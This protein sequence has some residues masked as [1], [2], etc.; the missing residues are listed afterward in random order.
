MSYTN[1]NL[2]T[3][4]SNALHNAIV[5]VG[6]KDRPPMLA[7]EGSSITTTEGYMENYKNVSQDIR[8]QVDA[9]AEVVQIILTWIDNDIYS[10]VNA[11]LRV[12]STTIVSKPQLKSNRLED[13]VMHNNSK[14]KKQ[15]VDDHRGNFNFSNNETS[16]TVCNDS[17]NAKTLKLVQIILF[18]IDFR[19]SKHMT[20]NLKLLSNSMEKFLSTMKF[21]NDQIAPILGYGDLYDIVTGLPKLKFVKDHLSSSCELGKAKR[22]SFKTKTTPSSKRRLQILQMDL[23]GPMRV[24]SFN[25]IEHQTSTAQTPEQNG[26]IERRNRTLVEAT[27]TMLSAAKVP[28]DGETLDKMK[29]KGDACIFVGYSTQSRAYQVYNKRTRV[30]VETIHVN[31]YELPHMVSD[32]VSFDP[33]PQCLTTALEHDCIS[34]GPQNQEN[35]PHIAEIVATSNELDLLFSL[36]FDE[37]LNEPTEVVSKYSA[38]NVVDAPDKRQQQNTT[39]STITTKNKRNE[40]NTVIHNKAHL[41]A[42]GYSQQEGIDFE[43]SFVPVTR[44][45]A[46]RLFIVYA[47]HKSFPIYQIDVKT[48]FLN[49]PL[50]K[51]VY[52]NQPDGFVDPYHPDKVYRLKK[53]L[54]GLKQAPRAC[55]YCRSLG[56]RKDEEMKTFDLAVTY[57]T[58]LMAAEAKGAK[59]DHLASKV[60]SFITLAKEPAAM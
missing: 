33:A 21:R 58:T 31:F 38:V 36:M 1:N 54:Y 20:G 57:A 47:A 55:C 22:N 30:I 14:G 45:E 28:L 46:V 56:H 16:V 37:L 24:E 15:Q 52:V 19:S 6:G 8:N 23:C 29:E 49:G 11:C 3:Q 18:I 9:E 35:V 4:T 40:E 53:A 32:H 39:Q 5:E 42:K 51:E 44:L 2:Q 43:V 25:G 60:E 27:R 34:P 13:R 48:A 41:V 10:I 50:K 12:I 17:L 59:C 7:P 26:V